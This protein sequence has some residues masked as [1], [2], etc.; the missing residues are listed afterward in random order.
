LS[1]RTSGGNADLDGSLKL[2]KNGLRDENLASLGAKV[3]NLGFEELDLL[4]GPAASHLKKAVDY[5]VEVDLMLVRHL[6]SSPARAAAADTEETMYVLCLAQRIVQC[7]GRGLRRFAR[8]EKSSNV[9][10]S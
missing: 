9:V 2:E 6:Q 7:R 8:D 3:A 1:G 5:V 4:T 10:G